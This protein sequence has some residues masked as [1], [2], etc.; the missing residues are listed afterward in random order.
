[1]VKPLKHQGEGFLL[2][3]PLSTPGLFGDAVA[4]VIARFQEVK[5]QASAFQRFIPCCTKSHGAA[6]NLLI[7]K[8]SVASQ[9]KAVLPTEARKGES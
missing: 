3:A 7:Q 4:T 1:M 8:E 6:A 5:K 9:A 2:D